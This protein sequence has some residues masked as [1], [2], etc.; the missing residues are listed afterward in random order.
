M[1]WA[2][3]AAPIAHQPQV[4]S[5]RLPLG[6]GGSGSKSSVRA[7]GIATSTNSDRFGE[8]RGGRDA[9]RDALA[10]MLSDSVG[11]KTNKCVPSVASQKTCH[12]NEPFRDTSFCRDGRA[13][14]ARVRDASRLLLVVDI[15]TEPGL[16][17]TAWGGCVKSRRCDTDCSTV[18]L[19]RG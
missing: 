2:L 15:S 8:A 18:A 10:S 4:P 19:A 6:Q 16:G 17:T 5:A 12:L 9:D 11:H 1:L 14:G 7:C 13:L 3:P